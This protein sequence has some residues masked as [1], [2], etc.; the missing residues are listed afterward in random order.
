MQNQTPL[1][2]PEPETPADPPKPAATPGETPAAASPPDAPAYVGDAVT[3]AAET[4]APAAPGPLFCH[5]G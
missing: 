2:F 4:M 3:D 5:G 1:P